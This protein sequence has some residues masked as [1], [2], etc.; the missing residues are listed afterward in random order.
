MSTVGPYLPQAEL[1]YNYQIQDIKNV[2]GTIQD[3]YEINEFNFAVTQ[4]FSTRDQTSA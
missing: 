1:N 4:N 2:T 3:N